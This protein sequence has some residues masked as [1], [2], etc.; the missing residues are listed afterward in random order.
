MTHD[1]ESILRPLRSEHADLQR[2][3][4]DPRAAASVVRVA[5]AAEAVLRRILRDDPTAPVELRLKAL[6]PDDL[7]TADLLAELRRRDRLP[8]E[9]AAAFHELAAAA[10]RLEDEGGEATPRDGELA[11]GVADGLERHVGAL[12]FDVPLEDPV[13]GAGDET[14]IPNPEDRDRAHPVP[15][16]SRAGRPVWPWVMG[17]AAL[18]LALLAFVWLRRGSD[19]VAEGEALYRRGDT[20]QALARFQEAAREEPSA[21]LPRLYL[22][23][24]HRHAGRRTEAAKE[25]SAGLAANPQDAG[26]NAE[27]GFLL[28]ETNRAEEAAGRFR[29]AVELDRGSARAWAGLVTSLRRAGRPAQAERVLS[30]A[31]PEVRALLSRD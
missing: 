21:A 20:A 18:A 8:M 13:L 17:A 27:L 19:P 9:L 25:L 10:R 26:L 15:H 14:L 12:A 29:K 2:L 7:P 23:Q 1:P 28:L 3:R 22:A 5:W 11:L 4:A 24:I 6:A 30:L 31:P 16:V